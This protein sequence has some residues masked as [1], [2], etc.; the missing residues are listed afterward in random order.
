MSFCC[1]PLPVA[2]NSPPPPASVFPAVS[3]RALALWDVDSSWGHNIPPPV[4][5]SPA[6]SKFCADRRARREG[7]SFVCP[8]AVFGLR[9]EADIPAGRRAGWDPQAARVGGNFHR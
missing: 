8:A 2:P 4:H 3:P 6:A 9:L 5:H 7:G 1:G